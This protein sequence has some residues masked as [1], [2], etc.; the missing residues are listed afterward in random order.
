MEGRDYIL[1]E[2]KIG[3]IKCCSCSNY[4]TKWH[5]FACIQDWMVKAGWCDVH[6]EQIVKIQPN[7][8]CLYIEDLKLNTPLRLLK[9]RLK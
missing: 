5:G 6:Y 2:A 4:A 3:T 7:K 9:K 8:D 1:S